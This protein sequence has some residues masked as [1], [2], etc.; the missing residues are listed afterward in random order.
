MSTDDHSP[1]TQGP[2]T[3]PPLVPMFLDEDTPRDVQPRSGDSP[4]GWE[5]HPFVPVDTPMK[6]ELAAAEWMR[7]LGFD[8]AFAD[9]VPGA[10]GGIDVEADDAVGQVKHYANSVGIA[11][12]QRLFGI[13][14]ERQV[15]GCFFALNGYSRQAVETANRT[16]VL[17]FLYTIH[18]QLEGESDA[19]LE[20]MAELSH[21]LDLAAPPLRSA[22]YKDTPDSSEGTAASQRSDRSSS[23]PMRLTP[24]EL[25]QVRAAL[26]GANKDTPKD[27]VLRQLSRLDRPIPEL[28]KVASAGPYRQLALESRWVNR[29]VL[30][31]AAANM[32]PDNSDNRL[33]VAKNPACP[34]PLLRSLAS[35]DPDERVRAAALRHPN[36]PNDVPSSAVNDPSPRVRRALARRLDLDSSTLMELLDDDFTSVRSYAA[37][38]PAALRYPETSEIAS[39][40]AEEAKAQANVR[41]EEV[42]AQRALRRRKKTV[43]WSL[44]GAAFVLLVFVLAVFLFSLV[45]QAISAGNRTELGSCASSNWRINQAILSQRND[46]DYIV[47]VDWSGNPAQLEGQQDGYIRVQVWTS[48]GLEAFRYPIS[49]PAAFKAGSKD[50]RGGLDVTLPPAKKEAQRVEVRIPE[51]RVSPS[52]RNWSVGVSRSRDGLNSTGTVAS[53]QFSGE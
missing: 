2:A 7:R 28:N 40:R 39:A 12:V 8:S 43:M 19:A 31:K 23:E 11:E 29:A 44:V 15:S 22:R 53:C 6:A 26:A 46:G 13:A 18:G 17:L 3:Q 35:T 24:L 20:S 36:L 42:E 34:D 25:N 10:D 33:A 27:A 48:D 4:E 14:Q 52:P 37:E 47:N 30:A 51:A 38:N 41:A 1:V 5:P 16:G 50:I 9:G 32:H 21:G 49:G 45:V